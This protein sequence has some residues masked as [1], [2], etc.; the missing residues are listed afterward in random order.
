M[1]VVPHM[2]VIISAWRRCLT[3][4][5]RV[6]DAWVRGRRLP[7]LP[8]ADLATSTPLEVD[9]Q[10]ALQSVWQ[11][12]RTAVLINVLNPNPTIFLPIPASSTPSRSEGGAAIPF[13]TLGR[14]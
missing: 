1:G 6:S 9:P 4:C 5:G 14:G 11:V 13:R 12:I 7:A 3:L 10:A 8:L 2:A